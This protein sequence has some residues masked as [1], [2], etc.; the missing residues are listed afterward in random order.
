MI[1]STHQLKRD[2]TNDYTFFNSDALLS[3]LLP[4]GHIPA[5]HCERANRAIRE[6]LV[7]YKDY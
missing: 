6:T 4:G 3:G 7:G 2:E 5:D 1:L